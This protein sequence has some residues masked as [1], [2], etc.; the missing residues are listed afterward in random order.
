MRIGLA[1]PSVL[2]AIAHAFALSPP[3]AVAGRAEAV[4]RSAE[5]RKE[6]L[7]GMAAIVKAR[8]HT[9]AS[10]RTH[11]RAHANA[12]ICHMR[13]DIHTRARA[14]TRTHT[15]AHTHARTHARHTSHAR[16]RR[17]LQ[18]V[19]SEMPAYDAIIPALLKAP[20]GELP[21][22]CSVKPGLPMKPMLAEPTKAPP[23]TLRTHAENEGPRQSLNRAMCGSRAWACPYAP[24]G[25]TAM[26]R[27]LTGDEGWRM[28]RGLPCDRGSARCWIG[29]Q[30]WCSRASTSTTASAR[31]ST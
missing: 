2:V 20:I 7:N 22:F 3:P 15:H 14:Y 25:L 11:T 16:T 8:S 26:A 9:R 29:S 31:K 13:R 10:T 24:V 1:E 19:H 18:D 4:P 27:V 12:Q 21:T 6:F 30:T 5:E 23:P 28:G 17:M